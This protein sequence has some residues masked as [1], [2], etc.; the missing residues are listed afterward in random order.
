MNFVVGHAPLGGALLL[1]QSEVKSRTL[2][3]YLKSGGAVGWV[4]VVLSFVALALIIMNLIRLR[5]EALL[6]DQV[7]REM[8]RRAKEHDLH[9]LVEVCNAPECDSSATRVLGP[10]LKHAMRSQF[11][12]IELRTTV[13]ES[14]KKEMDR[15]LR[16]TELIGLIA[17]VGPMLGLLGTVIGMIGAF[18]TIGQLEGAARSRELAT[19]MSM[20][21]VTTAEGL[22]V[23]IPCTVAYALIN[24]TTENIGLEDGDLMDD[25]V[26]LLQAGGPATAPVGAPASRAIPQPRPIPSAAGVARGARG[27]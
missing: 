14:G 1:A 25:W 6:P 4:L 13:E 21:L 20:A 26:G 2:L 27:E 7:V 24:R 18:G 5:R 9:G 8:D 16:P 22:I 12:L 3:D 17:A 23:A 10:A 15:L 11:G 19:F